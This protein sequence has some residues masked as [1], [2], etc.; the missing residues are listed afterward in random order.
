MSARLIARTT[1]LLFGMACGAKAPETAPP[2]GELVEI[3][4]LTVPGG[5]RLSADVTTEQGDVSGFSPS[6]FIGGWTTDAWGFE[7]IHPPTRVLAVAIEGTVQEGVHPIGADASG[8]HARFV[9]HLV[10]SEDEALFASTSG[11]F[12]VSGVDVSGSA[13]AQT[14]TVSGSFDIHFSNA[15]A[16]QASPEAI[17]QV[18]GTFDHIVLPPHAR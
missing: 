2:R 10:Y 14:F 11:T 6:T 3:T 16:A 17:L 8:T 13:G 15:A 7:A 9:D 1:C 18:A 4:S 12:T 5:P